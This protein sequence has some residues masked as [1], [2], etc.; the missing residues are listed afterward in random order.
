MVQKYNQSLGDRTQRQQRN[1]EYIKD[2]VRKKYAKLLDFLSR[3]AFQDQKLSVADI[4]IKNFIHS[5]VLY[6][7]KHSLSG[8]VFLQ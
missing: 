5:S 3:S 7:E 2:T 8:S 4:R 6:G 1:S